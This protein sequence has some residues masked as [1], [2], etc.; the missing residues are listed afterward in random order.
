MAEVNYTLSKS[1]DAY[2]I[3]NNEA[4]NI[5]Y[6]LHK[7][8]PCKA[9]TVLIEE[10]TIAPTA[11]YIPTLSLDGTYVLNVLSTET[12]GNESNVTFL[13]YLNLQ[14]SYLEDIFSVLCSCDCGC[15]NCEDLSVDNYKALLVTKT[16]LDAYKRLVFPQ[17]NASFNATNE[18]IH[19]IVDPVLYCDLA[20]EGITGLLQYNEKLTKDLIALDYLTLY[21]T[22]LRDVVDEEEVAYI[23]SKFNSEDILCCI[24]SLGVDINDIKT[25]IE[26]M[27]TITMNTGAYENLPP[28][29]IGDN[30]LATPNRTDFVYTMAMF[31]SGTTPPYNDPEGDLADAIRVDT[32]PPD[33]VLKLNGTPVIAGDIISSTD[34]DNSLFTFSPPDQDPLDA[35]DW[36]FSVRDVGSGQFS[37]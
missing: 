25:T 20:Q 28:D 30:T 17:Y 11:S 29:V 15:A 22:D 19:C 3:L 8:E 4:S 6:T 2:S 10:G 7:Q 14:L 21:F 36:T 16:K 26:N 9:E 1:K 23:K 34:I 13:H 27:G 37:S 32:L 5:T 12:P 31:T 35:D 18:T 24:N 33:G